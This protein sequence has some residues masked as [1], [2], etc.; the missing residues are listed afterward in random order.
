MMAT[1]KRIILS[2]L[3]LVILA[4]IANAA[5]AEGGRQIVSLDGAWQV[6][7]GAMAA[8]PTVFTHTILVPGLLDM[9]T[10]PFAEPGPKVADR[11]VKAQKDTRRDAFWYRR[12]FR[13]PGPLPAVARLKIGKAMFGTR[14]FLNGK[15]LGDHAPCYTPGWFDARDALKTG[16]N[17]LIVRVGADRDAVAGRAQSGYDGEKSRYI[18]GIY[19]S[20]ELI[21]SGSPHIVN[22]QA[23]PDIDRQAVTVHSWVRCS[24]RARRREAAFNRPRSGLA[25]GGRRGGLPDSRRRLRHR[26]GRRS[27]TIPVRGCRLWSP[28]DPF[29]YELEVRG[30]ADTLK[31]RFGMR[32][33]RLDPATGRAILNGKPYFMRGSNVTLYRFFED[34][35][36]GDKPWREAWVRRLHQAFREMHWNSLRYCIGFAPE[37][38]YRIADEE[39]LMIQDE[40]PIWLGTL[41]E[42]GQLDSEELAAEYREWMQE[43]WNHP[44]VVIWDACNETYSPETGKAIRKVRGLDFSNRPWD[45]GWGEPVAAGDSDEAHPYHF[46]F[47]P[48]QPFRLRDLA[49]DPGT[50]AGLLIAQPYAAEKLLRK[51]PIIINEYCGLWLNRDGT[52]T[53]LSRPVFDYLLDPPA[54]TAKRRQLGARTMAALTEY[55]R[56]HRLA[57]GVLHF[58][59]LGYSRPDGQTSDDWADL[60]KLAWDPDFHTYVRDAFAP[61]GLMLDVWAD[62]YPPGKSQEFPVIV[63]NDLSQPWKGE[64]RFRLSRGGE[65]LVEQTVPAEVAGL[66][67]TRLAFTATIP[68]QA[69]DYQ[70]EAA[71]LATPA[72]PVRSLRDFAV[73]TPRQREARRNLAEGRP[74]K[75]SSEASPA[76][77]AV[78]GKRDTRWASKPGNVQW[79]AVDLGETQTISRVELACF[80]GG[81]AK[82]Y[83][84]Q[85]SS[86]GED[87][88]DVYATDNGADKVAIR[89]SPTPARWVR[90]HGTHPGKAPDYVLYEMSVYR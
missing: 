49:Q 69:A 36:R 12:A 23:V 53:T 74:V 48:N 77:F 1:F 70:A 22:V 79:L 33:F 82:S 38:W 3:T 41:K 16:E 71:L 59:G 66:G 87:W 43:R 13:L 39:G 27:V 62:E 57:A 88:K 86:D 52:P 61:V 83:A 25:Q 40:F 4:G 76:K 10:P 56:A 75:A 21:L 32:S 72:G 85:V 9:A 54:T 68:E 15:L 26:P 84:I 51:N 67:S 78:D 14:V 8:P 2:A 44:C 35:K 18:P 34:S 55:F 42:P 81:F 60:D 30:E 47:G 29:L 24:P 5:R 46:I 11:A 50:K 37:A 31:T 89:F 20:V 45:N 28:E 90:F 6:D 7:E 80:W 17:E 64:V 19:D 65:T 58:C 73:L 63:I